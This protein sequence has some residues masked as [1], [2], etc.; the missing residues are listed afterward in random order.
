MKPYEKYVSKTDIQ[1]IHE[2]SLRILNE[3]GVKLEEM[4][5]F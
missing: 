5:F 3:V 2:E 1:I 4:S